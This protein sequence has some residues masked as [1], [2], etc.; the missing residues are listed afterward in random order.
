MIL[1]L[2][3]L[4]P[5]SMY[6]QDS[7]RVRASIS[8]DMTSI[9]RYGM[10]EI[11]FSHKFP[12]NWSAEG[13]ASLK[14][15]T[16]ATGA[17]TEKD[18]HESDLANDDE[19]PVNDDNPKQAMRIGFRYWTDMYMKGTSFGIGCVCRSREKA[20]LA[21][22]AGY[23]IRISGHAAV[24]VTYGLEIPAGDEDRSTVKDGLKLKLSYTF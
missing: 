8:A 7:R 3:I 19:A 15:Y 5:L 22:D 17:E 14:P 9:L 12:G 10:A 6:G 23:T 16:H 13:G 4:T 18:T 1:L 24:S 20:R 2:C 11:S 21:L